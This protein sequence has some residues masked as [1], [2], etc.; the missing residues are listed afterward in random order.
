MQASN[1]D[2]HLVYTWKRAAIRHVVFNIPWLDGWRRQVGPMSHATLVEVYAA[3]C[4]W[5]AL[6]WCLQRVARL[7]KQPLRGWTLL[8]VAGAIAGAVLVVPG[9]GACHRAMG[10]GAQC[11][12]QHS[13]DRD[14]RSSSSGKTSSREHIFSEREW[15]TA[16]VFGAIG[17]LTLYPMALGLGSFDPYEWGWS[18]SPLFLVI[19]VLTAWLIWRGNRF[20]LLLLL[21]AA[22]FQLRLLES[23]NYWD[24]L[25]DPIYSLVSLGWFAGG[26]VTSTRSSL[27]KRSS[28]T[29]PRNISTI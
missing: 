2:V 26:L 4:P 18:I 27:T 19:G 25:L 8:A 16:W 15:T 1:G 28:K 12:L 24:Y 3:V 20:G 10:R 14:A 11:E 5:L 9:P 21:A 29:L 23:T 22:A 6:S 7:F 17:G 13:T